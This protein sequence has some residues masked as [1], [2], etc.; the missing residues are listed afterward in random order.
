MMVEHILQRLDGHT[1]SC[2][3]LRIAM[4][5]PELVAHGKQPFSMARTGDSAGVQPRRL[6]VNKPLATWPS[7]ARPQ[8]PGTHRS[9][10]PLK[11][12]PMSDELKKSAF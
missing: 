10:R 5:A 8:R 1:V 3:V 9:R 12:P 7:G 2:S 11:I 4:P 6:Q